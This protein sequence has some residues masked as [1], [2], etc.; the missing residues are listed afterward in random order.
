[1][2]FSIRMSV[3]TLSLYVTA[4]D[5]KPLGVEDIDNAID[6][7]TYSIMLSNISNKAKL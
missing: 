7:K 6:K 2:T 5:N 1:M 3:K 4:K